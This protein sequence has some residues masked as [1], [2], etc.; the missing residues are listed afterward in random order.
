MYNKQTELNH[1]PWTLKG[2]N[3]KRWELKSG[4]TVTNENC[5]SNNGGSLLNAKK[6]LQ[7]TCV[8]LHFDLYL[9]ATQQQR[10]NKFHGIK[11]FIKT[12]FAPVHVTANW[13]PPPLS[14]SAKPKI[15][16]NQLPSTRTSRKKWPIIYIKKKKSNSTSKISK[17]I[18]F[19]IKLCRTGLC[20]CSD[21]RPILSLCKHKK[22]TWKNVIVPWVKMK[23]R[24]IS[25]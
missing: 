13:K 3:R 15:T 4:L 16:W 18:Y 5:Y 25:I 9:S 7:K 20:W 1:K 10:K 11:S 14:C 24:F 19:S 23:L 12:S 8:E 17:D 2:F 6:D 22:V 21:S